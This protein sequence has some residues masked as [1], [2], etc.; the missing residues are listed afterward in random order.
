[1]LNISDNISDTPVSVVIEIDVL[2]IHIYTY[3]SL[4]MYCARARLTE[5]NNVEYIRIYYIFNVKQ[6]LLS[7]NFRAA[8]TFRVFP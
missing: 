3:V 7:C 4:H 1:M 5:M 6:E 2:S 8:T